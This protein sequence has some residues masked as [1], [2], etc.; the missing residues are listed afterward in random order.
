M[1]DK[2]VRFF[3]KKYALPKESR[4]EISR[5]NLTF[6]TI[7]FALLLL[8]SLTMLV[9]VLLTGN[10]VACLYYTIMLV[11]SVIILL[12]RKPLLKLQNYFVTQSVVVAITGG[13]LLLL[14]YALIK[15]P[16]Y[17]SALI[18]IYI[19]FILLIICFDVSPIFHLIFVTAM[20]VYLGCVSSKCDIPVN[21]VAN[22]ALVSFCVF[23]LSMYKRSAVRKR[24]EQRIEIEKQNRQLEESNV[25]LGKQKA[26]L[27]SNKEKLE[28]YVHTQS[29]ELRDQ[30]ERIIRIQNNTIVSLSNLVE[31]RDEDT[32]DHVLRTRD[33]VE[34]IAR[35]AQA[36]GSFPELNEE[37][38][39]LYIKAAP[40]HDIGKIV[41]PDAVL[42][43]PGRLTPEEFELIKLHTSKGGKI[44]EDVLGAA[45]DEKYVTITKEIAT[46]HHEKFDG[47]GYPYGLSGEN[48]PLSAR[49]MAIAD[50]YD[51]LVSPRCYKEPMPEDE[52]FKIISESAGKHFDPVLAQLF[53]EAR[54]EVVEIHNRYL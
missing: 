50:V 36:A 25:E 22:N 15:S 8:F 42:K 23:F 18:N 31:N 3:K 30:N 49:I 39:Q 54:D 43:K 7:I 24:E 16:N 14:G 5:K 45:E 11:F 35:K 46:S 48:I 37:I 28:E 33:Y 12:L 40:M 10:N 47:S 6:L 1:L 21:V 2:I 27:R 4:S 53:V 17:M 32:G 19:T 44:V 41:V 9:V 13:I 29:K 34:L 26:S 38:I 20:S 51:A 52:A